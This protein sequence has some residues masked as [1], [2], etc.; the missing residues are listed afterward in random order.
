MCGVHRMKIIKLKLV[1]LSFLSQFPSSSVYKFDSV[2]T[3]PYQEPGAEGG[4]VGVPVEKTVYVKIWAK[5]L[6]N[7]ILAEHFQL[8]IFFKLS[9]FIWAFISIWAS[10]SEHI[11]KTE[12]FDLS[13]KKNDL[14]IFFLDLSTNN[15]CGPPWFSFLY[16]NFLEAPGVPNL[17]GAPYF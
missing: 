5:M 13:M 9:I 15:H 14:S 16:L 1:D 10:Q 2:S 11:F 12:H 17:K 7:F 8:S 4:E 6:A 3:L